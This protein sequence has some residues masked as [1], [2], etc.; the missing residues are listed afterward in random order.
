[1]TRDDISKLTT[2]LREYIIYNTP[3]S[4]KVNRD[5]IVGFLETNLG[6]WDEDGEPCLYDYVDVQ[7]DNLNN[8]PEL[9]DI[10]MLV[11]TL[12]IGDIWREDIIIK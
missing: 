2:K 12:S 10:N 11:V 9:I 1:M 6:K 5:A 4:S 7:C 8:R 3:I